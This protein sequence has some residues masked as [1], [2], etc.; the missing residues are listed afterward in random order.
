M[1][2]YAILFYN[3]LYSSTIVVQYIIEQYSVVYY[4]ILII[5]HCTVLCYSLKT[6]KKTSPVFAMNQNFTKGI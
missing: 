5:R 3:I 6:L 1:I 4:S 2:Y